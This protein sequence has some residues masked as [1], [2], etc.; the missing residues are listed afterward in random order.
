M[1]IKAL[2]SKQIIHAF[3]H[4][5]NLSSIEAKLKYI[6]AWEQLPWHGVAMFLAR[7]EVQIPLDILFGPDYLSKLDGRNTTNWIPIV[8]RGT[9]N[10]N[11]T[12]SLSKRDE[13]VGI[14]P[15]QI[16]RCELTT[17]DI[18][19]SWRLSS[20]QS[21]HINWKLGELVLILT[22]SHTKRA[23]SETRSPNTSPI[24]EPVLNECAGKVI[25]RPIDV[26]V[27]I[28]AELLGGYAFLNLRSPEKNQ[29]IQ[30]DTF[31][32]LT[33]GLSVIR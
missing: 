29:H 8:N 15:N 31:Y 21:W 10:S 32:K 13:M 11:V 2:Y 1:Q 14:G 27:K 7:I 24:R 17:G 16:Y 18:L 4:I 5:C 19:A 30:E 6:S 26:S 20:I 23:N 3:K 25:I 22:Q 28:I 9:P 12:V 33:T